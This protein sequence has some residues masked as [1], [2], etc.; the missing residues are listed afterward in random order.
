M[1]EQ[2]SSLT[3]KQTERL[4]QLDWYIDEEL[5]TVMQENKEYGVLQAQWRHTDR[6]NVFLFQGLDKVKK[7]I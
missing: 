2:E 1:T 5:P 6:M 4:A 3:P 7:T